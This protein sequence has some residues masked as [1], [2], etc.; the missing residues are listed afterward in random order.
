[1]E[2][3][4]DSAKR[5]ENK[6]NKTH[7]ALRKGDKQGSKVGLVRVEIK[8]LAGLVLHNSAKFLSSLFLKAASIFSVQC[9]LL[10]PSLLP[11]FLRTVSGPDSLSVWVVET[12]EDF[13][14][15][16]RGGCVCVI[17]CGN[18]CSV[19]GEGWCS[20]GKVHGPQG[21][22]VNLNC[23]GQRLRI[24]TVTLTRHM[25]A[26][27]TA[28]RRGA[29]MIHSILQRHVCKKYNSGANN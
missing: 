18:D 28:E 6:Q 16:K 27:S 22:V 10:P 2:K 24:P 3:K 20:S 19:D 12:Y 7:W 26:L 25:A 14:T 9:G 1:M 15:C 29:V 21:V 23:L 5:R 17:V 8:Q 11:A 4:N 13:L